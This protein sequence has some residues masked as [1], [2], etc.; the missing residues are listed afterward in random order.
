MIRH[1]VLLTMSDDMPAGQAE[2]IRAELT[3]MAAGLDAVVGYSVGIDAGISE[4]NATISAIGDFAS[5]EDYRTYSAD[6][7]H[8][9]IIADHIKPWV[10]NRSAVQYER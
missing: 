4:G 6:A 8:Q 5:V 3:E 10:T 7:R 2:L 9:Q 1:V